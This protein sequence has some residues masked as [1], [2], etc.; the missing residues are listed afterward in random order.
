[1]QLPI[2][3]YLHGFLSSGKSQ[4]GRWF[5][6]QMAQENHLD[7][8]ALKEGGEK[9]TTF[10]KWLTPTYPLASPQASIAAIEKLI[11]PLLKTPEIPLLL[12]GSSMG[13]FYAQYLGQKYGLPYVMINPALN[14]IPIFEQHLGRHKN[15][16]TGESFCIDLAYIQ[17]LKAMMFDTVEQPLNKHIPALLLLDEGDEV[18]DV[19]FAL[20]LYSPLTPAFQVQ[21]YEGGNHAFQHLEEAWCDI[22]RFAHQAYAPC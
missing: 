20:A 7:S 10:Q 16:V 14:P 18:I 17:Q 12:I 5:A 19:P 9:M 8:S 15:T 13:G 22:K 2:C 4:K 1:M 11:V 3:V 21:V 6:E